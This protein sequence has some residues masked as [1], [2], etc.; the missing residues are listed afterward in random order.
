MGSCNSGSQKQTDSIPLKKT[1]G[2]KNYNWTDVSRTDPHYGGQR[3]VNAQV[4]YPSETKKSDST[5][6]PYYIH[7]KKAYP[8]LENWTTSDVDAVNSVVTASTMDGPLFDSNKKYP[9]LIFSPS[10]GG[11]LSMYTYYAERLAAK[12]YVVMGI[13]HLYESEYVLDQQ[14]KVIAANLSFH[15]SLKTLQIPEEITAERYREVKGKREKILGSDLIFALNQLLN[16][17]FFKNHINEAQIG[18]YGHSIGGAA[19][20]YASMLDDRIG[21][22]INFDG[23]PPSVA[24]AKGIDAPFL[25]I[26][27]LTDYN[28]HIGYGK[29]HKRRNDFCTLNRSDS[30]RVLIDGFN[31]NSFLDINYYL[32]EDETNRL[33]EERNLNLTLKYMDTFLNTYLLH[34]SEDSLKPQLTD[35]L[36][37]F[38]FPTQ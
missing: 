37:I 28:N 11:N 35:S 38:E 26:E 23:T 16:E 18:M 30:W 2:L 13:N 3:I 4:W 21:A 20:V 32:A 29:L 14:E 17:P 5:R 31:H 7:I 33:Q 36:Q 27:D 34:S 1:T 8:A 15:D 22:V 9:L 6:A 25:F 19:V 24:L 12:G 10:L